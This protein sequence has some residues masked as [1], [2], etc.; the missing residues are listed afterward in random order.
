MADAPSAQPDADEARSASV[1]PAALAPFR[2]RIFLALWIASLAS[3]FGSLIQNVGAAWLMTALAGSADMVA[4]V[5]V[6]TVLPIMLLSLPAGA[7]ADVWDRRRVMLVA[8]GGLLVVS[9]LLAG[10]AW[11]GHLAPGPLIG[12]TFLVGAGGA[13]Y[14]PAWQASVREQV[15]RAD[16]PAAVALNSVA[17]NLARAAGPGLGGVLVAWAGAHAAFAVN[18]VS[19][20]G[21]IAVLA[22]WRR[23]AAEAALPPETFA[24][25]MLSGLRFA[26]LSHAL[27][28]V[29]VRAAAFG[30]LAGALWALIPLVAR[31]LLGGG[32][33]TYGAL[34][35]AFGAG[36]VGGAL[37]GT[38][39]RARVTNEG[40]VA[41]G[42]LA[43]AAA[44]LLAALSPVLVLTLAALALGGAAWLLVLSTFNVT[45]QLRSPR[46][47]VGRAMAI[48]QAGAFGGLALGAWLW[49]VVAARYGVPVGLG[50]P[51]LVLAA[52]ALLGRVLPMPVTDAVNL[53]PAGGAAADGPRLD[54]E[55]GPVVTSTEYRIPAK[56]VRAFLAASRRLQR[57]RGRNGARRFALLHDT[58]DAEVWIERF[59]LPTWLDYLRLR[60]RMTVADGAV[61]DEVLALHAGDAPPL[62]RHLLAHAPGAA[63]VG[64]PA[65]GAAEPSHFD[66]SLPPAL[67]AGR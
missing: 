13:L 29:L 15:P 35:A 59:E 26:R 17:Y 61:E 16:L 50:A 66:P 48:Y 1:A 49:G 44:S 62:T 54:P 52:S 60:A 65:A 9:A 5:Q 25:A 36:A 46:W 55:G 39:V 41:G 34:L 45:V 22:A 14:G 47:I 11:T 3:N 27:Q 64:P 57:M 2:S 43:F 67:H 18:A 20:L 33:I 23:P 38:A 53:E 30:F 7:A 12:L 6:A 32:A 24:G 8:Q 21:L 28:A 58:R 51:A 10:L 19:Y 31:D 37:A 4:L 42:S 63:P 40:I 56:D